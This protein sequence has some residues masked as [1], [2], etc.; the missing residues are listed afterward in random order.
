MDI[1]A[2]NTNTP[3]TPT[4]WSVAGAALCFAVA[5]G[6]LLFSLSKAGAAPVSASVITSSISR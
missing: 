4:R 3:G 5:A 1:N 6:L 2:Y